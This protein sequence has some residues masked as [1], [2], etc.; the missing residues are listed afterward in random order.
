MMLTRSRTP[1]GRAMLGSF[2]WAMM[3]LF[4][5]ADGLAKF[6]HAAVDSK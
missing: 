4:H 5:I 2:V 3:G 6:D 1:T